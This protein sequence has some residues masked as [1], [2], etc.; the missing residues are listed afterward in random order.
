MRRIV[1]AVMAGLAAASLALL[2]SVAYA[3]STDPGSDASDDQVAST[4]TRDGSPEAALATAP[5]VP[6]IGAVKQ[7]VDSGGIWLVVTSDVDTT[8]ANQCI[9]SAANASAVLAAA[10]LSVQLDPNGAICQIGGFPE[11][12]LGE[13][14]NRFW[15]H[16]T[17]TTTSSWTYAQLGPNESVPTPGT[18]EGWCFGMQCSPPSVLALMNGV[19][20]LAGFTA[21]TSAPVATSDTSPANRSVGIA[22][23]VVLVVAAVAVIAVVRVKSRGTS[24]GTRGRAEA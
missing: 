18:L 16:F 12:C 19:N 10:G 14:G 3:D 23:V 20:A 7:C 11:Q 15:Q 24:E 4:L 21:A 6:P 8:L 17:A 5:A 22:I 9:A 1:M 13:S 2:P